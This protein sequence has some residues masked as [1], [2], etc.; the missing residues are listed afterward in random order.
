MSDDCIHLDFTASVSISRLFSD[1]VPDDYGLTHPA[2]SVAVDVIAAC[3]ACG[4]RVRFEGPI[5]VA[6]GPGAAPMV[7][8][9]GLE[10][11]AAGHLGDNLS[12]RISMRLR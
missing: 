8:F 2:E 6:V 12:P 11:H 9:D 4:K 3:A 7:S 5:G 10:L 1:G